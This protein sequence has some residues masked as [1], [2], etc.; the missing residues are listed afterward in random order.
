M[1]DLVTWLGA[2]LDDDERTAALAA[3]GG[4]WARMVSNYFAGATGSDCRAFP[5]AEAFGPARVLAEVEAKRAIL[6]RYAPTVEHF[7]RFN[8][9]D[10]SLDLLDAILR[11]LALPYRDRPGW[12]PEWAPAP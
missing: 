12:K 8:D 9:N 6:R 11:D 4:S 1:D 5:L 7:N 3:T 10:G 2:A